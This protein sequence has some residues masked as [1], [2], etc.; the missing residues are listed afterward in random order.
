MQ[1]SATSKCTFKGIMLNGRHLVCYYINIRNLFYAYIY[2]IDMEV[3]MI[4]RRIVTQMDSKDVS[5]NQDITK[6]RFEKLWKGA[7]NK[8]KNQAVKVGGYKDTRTFTNAKGSG[9]LSVRMVVSLAITFDVDPFYL[10]AEKDTAGKLTEENLNQ[11]LE[12]HNFKY[13]LEDKCGNRKKELD[14]YI[15]GVIANIDE[16]FMESMDAVSEDELSTLLRSILIK[17]KA[18]NVSKEKMDLLK[19]LLLA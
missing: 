18:G 7:S 10:T 12:A 9:H 4:D 15:K 6:E 14:S 1:H 11:F 8:T 17:Y 2:I 3:S 19:V 16:D 5:K 13:L